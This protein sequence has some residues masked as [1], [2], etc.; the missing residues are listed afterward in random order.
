MADLK[1]KPSA[2][3]T[4]DTQIHVTPT[5]K[6]NWN[7]KADQ[8]SLN[9]HT[10]NNDVHVSILEKEAWNLNTTLRVAIA[11]G[12][13]SV[14][15]ANFT[16]PI[17]TLIDGMRVLVK[18]A[19]QN[20]S[21]NVTFTPDSAVTKPIR[22]SNNTALSG[23]DIPSAG[24]WM[25]LVFNSSFDC[26]ILLNP[27]N[28][29]RS[30]I[31]D[32]I[33]PAHNA[34]LVLING[35]VYSASGTA[36]SFNYT[37]SG[38][39]GDQIAYGTGISNL[40][41]LFIPSGSPVKKIYAPGSN[42]FA[43]CENGELF[44]WGINSVG[45]LGLGHTSYVYRPTFLRNN[46]IDIHTGYSTTEYN[47]NQTP[48]FISSND[49][50]I[51]GT[52]Y[53]GNGNLGLGDT[54][55]R[56]SWTEIP[57]L[58]TDDRIT[59]IGGAAGFTLVFKSDGRLLFTGYNSYGAMGFGDTTTRTSF[60]DN[61]MAWA[62]VSSG[63][64]DV[65][66]VGSI[67]Y[68]DGSS[69]DVIN[70]TIA[71]LITLPDNS[72]IV[73]SC[74]YNAYGGLGNGNTTNSTTPVSVLNSTNVVDIQSYGNHAT[75]NM[76]KNDGS[77]YSWGYNGY[78]QVG[79]SSTTSR[80]TPIQIMTDVKEFP[81]SGLNCWLRGYETLTYI[82][83]NDGSLYTMGV[84]GTYGNNGTGQTTANTIIPTRVAIPY[85]EKVVK[86][87]VYSTHA[88]HIAMSQYAS[89]VT[90]MYGETII[91]RELHTGQQQIVESEYRH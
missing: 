41:P 37:A 71:M 81:V 43:L 4:T 34:L 49:G 16:S 73:R 22:K 46:V 28:N 10:S 52:G 8:S 33:V 6:T 24:F 56:T 77:V 48:I 53:N 12:T 3:H 70:A 20:K 51:Y 42:A 60:I 62:G 44:G 38:L 57:G 68:H 75:F 85:H 86:V 89:L 87:G 2:G 19:Y 39:D 21:V 55:N 35:V 40:R 45:A 23:G 66:L 50:K 26:W 58:T 29:N 83:K 84:C 18:S 80:S 27:G 67:R 59:T 11:A 47:T 17:T 61:T 90:G 7:N 82:L 65:K 15:L 32:Q 14:I 88:G 36:D 25:E 64:L 5:D 31:P 79:D 13:E 74:G 63:L 1:G 69:S 9:A 72:K 76:L 54:T 78:G 30:A 91:I